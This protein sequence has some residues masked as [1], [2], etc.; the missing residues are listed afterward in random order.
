M[1]KLS[2]PYGRHEYKL[3]VDNK[4]CFDVQ[5]PICCDSYGGYNN[6]VEVVPLIKKELF[7]NQVTFGN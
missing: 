6:L 2:L 1:L 4:W 5:K 7:H 3:K